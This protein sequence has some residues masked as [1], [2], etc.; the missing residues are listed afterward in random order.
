MSKANR[1]ILISIIAL[2]ILGILAYPKWKAAHSNPS[3][4]IAN[5]AIPSPLGPPSSL[6]ASTPPGPVMPPLPVT[7]KILLTKRMEDQVTSTGT[8]MANEEV[9]IRSEIQGKVKRI[10]FKEGGQVKKGDLLVK[11]D[12]EE[13]QG[14][15]LKAQ[16][17][18]KLA[19]DNEYRMRMQLKIE[20]V[21][22]KDYDQAFNEL[23]L[24]KAGEQILR[25]QLSKTE[26][27][28]PFSGIVGLKVISEGALVSGST[29]ITTLQEI[30]PIKI[31]FSVPGKYADWIKV[32]MGVTYKVQGI[33][34]NQVGK[35]YAIDPKIDAETRTLHIRALGTNANNRILPGSF[36][37]VQ[38]P[39]Q[40]VDKA[41]LIPTE[42]MTADARGAKVYLYHGGKAD[43]VFVQAGLRTDS[44]VQILKGVNQGDTLITSGIMQIRPGALVTLTLTE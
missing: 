35:I 41:L 3:A 40:V 20:A 39:L 44:S 29:P 1:R 25:A 36:A 5:S 12:D 30:N 8:I 4:G 23:N 7:A 6:P 31:D 28:A 19:E 13:L 21:S 14:N 10:A 11:I 22:Q 43:P 37:T 2:S 38:I 27:H 9:E 33:D 18:R 17:Q 16:S 42:A 26:L 15:L 34:A 32:G 24:A